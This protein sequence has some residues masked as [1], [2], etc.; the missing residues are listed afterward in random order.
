MGLEKIPM[1]FIRTISLNI[2]RLGARMLSS[3]FHYKI[4]SIFS[5]TVK[6]NLFVNY[7]YE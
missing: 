5:M 4:V 1:N 3:V 6:M 2:N 7:V